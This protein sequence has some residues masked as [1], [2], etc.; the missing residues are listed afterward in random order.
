MPLLQIND[1]SADIKLQKQQ[2][3]AH[4]KMLRKQISLE[5]RELLDTAICANA[6]T[7]LKNNNV[8]TLLAYYP[9]KG[10]PNIKGIISWAFS[11][12]KRVAF[13]ICNS[14]DCTLSFRC[15]ESF[16]QLISGAYDIPEPPLSA[17]LLTD[18][19][20]SICL[21]PGLIFDTNG[22]RM[23]YGKGYY[24]RFMST[25]NGQTVGL[26]YETFYIN[27]PLPCDEY[28]LAVNIVITE[29]GIFVQNAKQQTKH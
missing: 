21:V 25:Y 14:E 8:D 6:I 17:P 15:V 19:D 27:S 18:F 3:R 9:V 2:L 10:E 12:K 24:D 16:S 28:D 13:P 7:F 23:G 5:A 29:G 20:N 22:N 1:T 26:V 4:V 11:N